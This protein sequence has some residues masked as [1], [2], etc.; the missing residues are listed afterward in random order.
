MATDGKVIS[1]PIKTTKEL[2]M[3]NGNDKKN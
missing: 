3:E 2:Y 1:S